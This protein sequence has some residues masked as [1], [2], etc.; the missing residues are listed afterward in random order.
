MTAGMD[1]GSP[2]LLAAIVEGSCDTMIS[3]DLDGRIMTW[4][5]GAERMFCYSASEAVGRSVLMIFPEDRHHELAE[6]LEK[7]KAGG[8]AA[9]HETTRLAKNGVAIDVAVTVSPIRNQQGGLAG[10]AM[11]ARDVTESHWMAATLDMTLAKLQQSLQ[12]A[13]DA[14]AQHRRFLADAAH[15][16][17]GPIAGIRAAGEALLRGVHEAER[18]LLL[19]GL[20]RETT[21]AGRLVSSLLRMARLDQAEPIS[22]TLCD[23]VALCHEEGRRA[24]FQ[25]P[26]LTISVVAEDKDAPAQLDPD[27]V[28]E[29]L[30]NLLDNARR[31]AV[32]RI[33]VIVEAA[34][35][36]VEIRVADDG[37]GLAADMVERAFQRFVSLDGR[38]GS[39]LGLPIARALARAHGG[40]L[41]YEGHAF[42]LR[43]PTRSMKP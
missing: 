32:H 24:A 10:A 42:V 43:L 9:Q 27:A 41:T 17:R 18:D 36:N 14:E 35:D 2:Y 1:P 40:E 29:I 31:H 12:N 6:S 25:A 19:A 15:Q 5:Q 3:H 28:R 37:P 21:N 39:G 4:N 38:G 23:L 7:V 33:D 16:L 30:S 20:V 11:V 26:M 8:I 34:P 22:T 13:Q